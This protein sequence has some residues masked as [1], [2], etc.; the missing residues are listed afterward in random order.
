MSILFSLVLESK[1]FSSRLFPREERYATV[2][3]LV[4]LPLRFQFRFYSVNFG[5]YICSVCVQ[6]PYPGGMNAGSSI[7]GRA[8]SR[9]SP[10]LCR[11][12]WKLPREGLATCWTWQTRWAI[13]THAPPSCLELRLIESRDPALLLVRVISGWKI[14]SRERWRSLAAAKLFHL[15][16]MDVECSLSLERVRERERERK[17][18]KETISKEPPK[19]LQRRDGAA[20]NCQVRIT[21]LVDRQPSSPSWKNATSFSSFPSVYYSFFISLDWPQLIAALIS[22]I[23]GISDSPIDR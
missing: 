23:R 17:K 6:V 22:A 1:S 19:P 5:C 14:Y 4:D 20:R 16:L 13:K 21:P 15:A 18:G 2:L 7:A 10:T 9:R 12:W 3:D 11:N 8:T